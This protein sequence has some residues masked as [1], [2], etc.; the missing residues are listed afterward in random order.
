[1]LATGEATGQGGHAGHVLLLGDSVFDNK[2][3]VAGGPDV[4]AH[5]RN[6]LPA[7]WRGSLAAVNGA[8]TN[9]VIRQ[10][11]L[12]GQEILEHYGYRGT[13]MRVILTAQD[14]QTIRDAFARAQPN[15]DYAR[16]YAAAIARRQ[17]GSNRRFVLVMAAGSVAGTL[18]PGWPA[19]RPRT[20][21]RAAAGPRNYPARLQRSRSG[22]TG[23]RP[24]AGP[25]GAGSK[26][27]FSA[28][29]SRPAHDHGYGKG[30]R[31]GPNRH[32]SPSRNSLTGLRSLPGAQPWVSRRRTAGRV[33]KGCYNIT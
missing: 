5:L 7:G 29:R 3:Y 8:V 13:V 10:G 17:L 19:V 25:P 24:A 6:R 16:L 9:D 31:L 32:G 30:T 28:V 33:A 27:F 20:G 21:S 1:V 4:V 18:L 14:P 26:P 15:A 22:G 2:G 11:Q 12:I 23:G